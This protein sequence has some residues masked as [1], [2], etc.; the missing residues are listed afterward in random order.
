MRK[1]ILAYNFDSKRL[2]ALKILCMMLKTQL[3]PVERGELLQPVG[4]LAGVPGI[5]PAAE[6]YEGSEAKQEMIFLCGFDRP[7]LDRLLQGIR[8]SQL[9][10]IALKAMLTAHNAEWSGLKLIGE[11]SEEHAYMTAQGKKAVPRH[12]Q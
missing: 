3:R 12:E 8:R 5:G 9:K 7:A 2:Q 6:E 1:L 11:L 4:Y 10:S